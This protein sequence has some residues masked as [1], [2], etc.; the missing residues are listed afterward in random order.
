MS[1]LRHI[2]LFKV[3]PALSGVLLM[4][5]K[6][7][8]KSLW[9][10]VI[11]AGMFCLPAPASRKIDRLAREF[12]CEQ[13]IKLCNAILISHP[14]DFY[15][16]EK[17]GWAELV[18]KDYKRAIADCSKAIRIRPNCARTY[19]FRADASLRSDHYQAAIDDASTAIRL[20]PELDCLIYLIRGHALITQ[21]KYVEAISDLD[22]GEKLP[23]CSKTKANIYGDR[24]FAHM[25]LNQYQQVVADCTRAIAIEPNYSWTY[26]LRSNGY[27]ELKQPD[28]ALQDLNRAILLEPSNAENLVFRGLVFGILKDYKKEI[29]DMRAALRLNPEPKLKAVIYKC[30]AQS[31][32]GLGQY[33][34]SVIA[35]NNAIEIDPTDSETWFDRGN[36]YGLLAEVDS[37]QSDFAKAIELDPKN[38]RAYW[39]RGILYRNNARYEECISDFERALAINPYIGVA[40]YELPI[41]YYEVGRYEDALRICSQAIAANENEMDFYYTRGC[42]REKLHQWKQAVDDFTVSN[43]REFAWSWAYYHRAKCYAQLGDHHRCISDC[44]KAIQL[45]P[46]S[47][48]S[49]VIY[50]TRAWSYL[51]TGDFPNAILDNVT[52]ISKSARLWKEECVTIWTGVLGVIN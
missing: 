36:A 31:Y 24:A 41:A 47:S 7:V 20:S 33:R 18:T 40:C 48:D 4:L 51:M 30:C 37:A 46:D 23:S 35:C 32:T 11:F 13:V 6:N 52:A 45:D 38:L 39:T 5:A 17:R 15:A 10:C 26:W 22:I 44:S 14:N 12:K 27:V 34:A 29:D 43:N 50:I 9:L 16:L 3:I 19:A 1:Q 42:V 25:H 8:E 21:K 2:A 28:K 49:S